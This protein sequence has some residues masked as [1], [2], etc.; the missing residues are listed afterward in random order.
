LPRPDAQV[1]GLEVDVDDAQGD[2]LGA[3]E[4]AAVA[5]GQEGGGVMARLSAL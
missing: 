5:E 1:A 4:T 3:A 2:S